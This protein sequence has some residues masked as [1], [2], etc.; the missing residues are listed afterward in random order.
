[1]ASELELS[2]LIH[3]LERFELIPHIE[4]EIQATM[5][6]QWNEDEASVVGA[7][8][9]LATLRAVIY[10][11]GAFST[12]HDVVTGKRIMAYDGGVRLRNLPFDLPAAKGRTDMLGLRHFSDLGVY[13][14]LGT[15]AS[16][17][18]YD[19]PLGN[20]LRKYERE[21][22]RILEQEGLVEVLRSSAWIYD[23]AKEG[24]SAEDHE[25]M[26]GAFTGAW[27]RAAQRPDFGVIAQVQELLRD[28]DRALQA[29]RETLFR[30]RQDEMQKLLEF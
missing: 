7:S 30:S 12:T 25:H 3:V 24:D 20:Q 11:P 8:V 14:R 17:A 28:T 23:H 9:R 29:K 13:R 6:G 26:V 15:L 18:H 4:P 5:A 27:L 22:L 2:M 1:M 16:H 19:G 10:K 21:F